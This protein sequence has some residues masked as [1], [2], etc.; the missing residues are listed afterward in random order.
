MEENGATNVLD[1]REQ[2]LRAVA[3]RMVEIDEVD[4]ETAREY[5]R[6]VMKHGYNSG[7]L[8]PVGDAALSLF[9]PVV[10]TILPFIPQLV[11]VVLML[12]EKQ[13]ER[14]ED[15]EHRLQAL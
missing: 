8:K 6:D 9:Q 3:Y 7:H 12:V 4:A 13:N 15:T 1:W 2:L 5:V 14:G 10:G 11:S